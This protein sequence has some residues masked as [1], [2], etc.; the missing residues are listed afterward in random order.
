M[1][2]LRTNLLVFF[3]TFSIPAI[4]LLSQSA[5][6]QGPAFEVAS[7]KP[8]NSGSSSSSSSFSRGGYFKS[9]NVTLK[10][11][12]LAYYKLFE[13]QLIG[14]PEWVSTAR[15]DIE[16]RTD[17][18]NLNTI[19][20][21]AAMVQSL[22]EDRFQLKVHSETREE[23]V[24]MLNVAKSGLKMETTIAG[25]PG[26]GGLRPGT[27]QSG[28]RENVEMRASGTTIEHLISML[29]PRVE[30]PIIDNTGLTGKYD[31]TLKFT[32]STVTTSATDPLGPDIFTAV[33]E[34]LGL[35]LEST[36]G[37]VKVLVIDSVQ[38]PVVN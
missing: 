6:G 32:P 23:P 13:F 1:R 16:A 7:I 28:G 33:Q 27:S 34:Q 19:E 20:Q 2:N 25:R 9:T 10:Q 31:F 26:P 38:K 3:V 11:L 24:F 29:A 8:D 15:F 35:R 22:L 4:P 36:K 17:A 18:T 14:G 12:I 21:F 5:A 30:R 37:P